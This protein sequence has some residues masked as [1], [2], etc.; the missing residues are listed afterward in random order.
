MVKLQD[1]IPEHEKSHSDEFISCPVVTQDAKINR[2]RRS[3]AIQ[4]YSYGPINPNNE[5]IKYWRDKAITS[6]IGSVDEAKES[7]CH[8]C[9]FFNISVRI[10]TC[11]DLAPKPHADSQIDTDMRTPAERLGSK[12][13]IDSKLLHP[14]GTRSKQDQPQIETEAIN[15]DSSDPSWDTVDAG[16]I[17]YCTALKFMAAGSR[18]CRIWKQGGPIK[19]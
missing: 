19:D 3:K 13:K 16:K 9:A 7:R 17:G 8:N 18:S 1:L 12:E 10:L 15:L 4:K 2:I 14:P 11:L 6:R 5:N